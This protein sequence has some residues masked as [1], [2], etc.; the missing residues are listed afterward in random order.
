MEY[1]HQGCTL[2]AGGDIGAAEIISDTHAR[3]AREHGGITDLPGERGA[4][5]PG[6]G[7]A[8]QDGL[9]V[10]ADQVSRQANRLH[11]LRMAFGQAARGIQQGGVIGR[12]A[13]GPVQ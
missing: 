4:G 13:L 11:R 10:K 1:R 7:G 5:P 2:A 12:Q 6:C 9:A 3:A 8:M